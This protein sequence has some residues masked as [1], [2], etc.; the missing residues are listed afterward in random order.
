MSIE[1]KDIK[2]DYT[3]LLKVVKIKKSWLSGFQRIAQKARDN[4]HRY[5]DISNRLGGLI[6]W[7]FIAAIHNL[8]SGM[9]FNK[10]L[11]NGDPLTRRTRRV[12]A[13]RPKSGKPPFTWEESAEDALRM[14]GLHEITDWSW[15]R[16]CYELERYNGFGYRM[17]H[18]GTLS[19]YL[20]SGTNL[21]TKGKYVADG[22]WSST[23]VSKQAGAIGILK[24]LMIDDVIAKNSAK[25]KTN[26]T[27]QKT[28][29]GITGGGLLAWNWSDLHN[30]KT[31]MQDNAG[32]IL[33]IAAGLTVVVLKYFEVKQKQDA[34]DGRYVPSGL[35]DNDVE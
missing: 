12:P 27:L 24:L 17:Y 8:E 19:P 22:K 29:T 34:K 26:D 28:V 4:Q 14:K 25:Q 2:D 18:P 35:V 5:E 33:L 21:Y 32:I 16:I 13:G 1:F 31:F 6:P 3:R 10:H 9:N 15:E 30:I 20:W 7:Q 11:H 23:A